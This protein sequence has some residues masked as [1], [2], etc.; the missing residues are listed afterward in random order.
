MV[1]SWLLPLLATLSL[2]LVVV[3]VVVGILLVQFTSPHGAVAV[4]VGCQVIGVQLPDAGAARDPVLQPGDL[5]QG[6]RHGA[7]C[8]KFYQQ[9][10]MQTRQDNHEAGPVKS[11]RAS[12]HR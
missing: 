7:V 12:E 3:V 9:E 4:R 1:T 2:C 10:I 11:S 8:H 5:C 6:L